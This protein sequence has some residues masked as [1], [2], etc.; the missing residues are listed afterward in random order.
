MLALSLLAGVSLAAMGLL[1]FLFLKLNS[2]QQEL[3]RSLTSTNQSLLNQVRARDIA[4][5][6]GLQNATGVLENNEEDSQYQS[7][8]DRE[9]AA[10]WA[11]VGQNHALGESITDDDLENFRTGL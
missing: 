9:M 8:E 1:V 2:Q 10:Y 3:I 4:A 5:L 6:S 7:T 11:S